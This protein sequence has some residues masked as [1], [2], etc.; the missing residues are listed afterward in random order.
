MNAKAKVEDSVSL[1]QRMPQ[2]QI[3]REKSMKN[4]Q[5]LRLAHQ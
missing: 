2:L 4:R 1:D 5:D 3:L